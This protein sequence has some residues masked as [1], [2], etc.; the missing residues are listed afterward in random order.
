MMF[1]ALQQLLGCK[2]DV[3]V[4][5]KAEVKEMPK[6]SKDAIMNVV[7]RFKLSAFDGIDVLPKDEKTIEYLKSLGLVTVIEEHFLNASTGTIECRKTAKWNSWR[8]EDC[9]HFF[10]GEMKTKPSLVADEV[11]LKNIRQCKRGFSL[12]FTDTRKGKRCAFFEDKR[13]KGAL[14]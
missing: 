8:C 13:L 14:E 12:Q 7:G 10:V 6:P 11:T 2:K 1:K 5:P 9:A 4:E 3:A